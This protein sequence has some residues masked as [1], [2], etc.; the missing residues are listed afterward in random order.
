MF[1]RIVGIFKGM[2]NKGIKKLETPEVLAEQAQSELE[3]NVKK[4]K[5]AVL[6]GI[7]TEKALERQ[8]KDN[9]QK[10][11]EWQKRA[12]L[13]VTQGNDEIARQCLEKRQETAQL[14]ETQTA[15]LEEQKRANAGLKKQLASAENEL[16]NFHTKKKELIARGQA[17]DALAS[18]NEH[19]SSSPTGSSSSSMDK[20]EQKI[21]EKEI[22]N[23]ALSEMRGDDLVDEF[24]L[25][26]AQGGGDDLD[27]ELAALKEQMGR[28]VLTMNKDGSSD[29]KAIEDTTDVEEVDEK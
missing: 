21:L 24:K 25:L 7:T 1:N 17:M 4:L 22:R 20:W 10:N 28:P 16:R 15:Q 13:A 19:L 29:I 2:L 26:E 3:T 9:L 11:G 23:E 5:E 18:A 6:S 8:I 12:Q 14:A 27:R